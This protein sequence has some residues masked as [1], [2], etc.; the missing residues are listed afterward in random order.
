MIDD[1]DSLLGNI[2]EN[3]FDYSNVKDA[4][5]LQQEKTARRSDKNTGDSAEIRSGYIDELKKYKALPEVRAFSPGYEECLN[6]HMLL[7]QKITEALNDMALPPL[8]SDIIKKHKYTFQKII[9]NIEMNYNSFVTKQ[10]ITALAKKAK[11]DFHIYFSVEEQNQQRIDFLTIK[12]MFLRIREFNSKIKKEWNDIKAA[13][14]VLNIVKEGT[15]YCQQYSSLAAEAFELCSATDIFASYLSV[16]LGIPEDD[17]DLLEKDIYNKIYFREIMKYSYPSLFEEA[18]PESDQTLVETKIDDILDPNAEELVVV[19]NPVKVEKYFDKT[20]KSFSV[21]DLALP[22]ILADS[23]ADNPVDTSEYFTVKGSLAWNTREPYVMTVMSAEY[24]RNIADLALTVL[25]IEDK[26]DYGQ[27]AGSVKRAMIK[28]QREKNSGLM[29]RYE[30]YLF[31]KF[32]VISSAVA[33]FFGFDDSKL[34]IYHMGP[35]TFWKTARTL[36]DKDQTAVC[37]KHL[38]ANRI[39]RFIP[40]EF[41]KVTVLK[42]YEANINIFDLPFDR[43]QDFNEIKKKISEKYESEKARNLKKVT[44]AAAQHFLKTGKKISEFALLSSKASE[45]FGAANIPVYQ[46]FLDKSIFTR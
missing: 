11:A 12:E 13:F 34:L 33:E 46:R 27:L 43:I 24:E 36:F 29:T 45:L 26:D 25:F 8:V 30:E 1:L 18:S 28:Y 22:S 17:R 10:N 14:G 23:A 5:K 19:K 40:E 32:T 38:S 4:E 20:A 3:S 6:K 9:Q 15:P 37:L 21:R 42:W 35:L 16:V 2:D 44:I 41:I 31:K 39:S 7:T